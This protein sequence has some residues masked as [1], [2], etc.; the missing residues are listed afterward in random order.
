MFDD[1]VNMVTNTHLH[2]FQMQTILISKLTGLL[3]TF[4]QDSDE[5]L[6]V[7]CKV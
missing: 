4:S 6:P 7:N 2:N 1:I 3:L 5:C